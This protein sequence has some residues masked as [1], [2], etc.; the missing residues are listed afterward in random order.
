MLT[1]REGK[2]LVM[3]QLGEQESSPFYYMCE[4]Q[5]CDCWAIQG[6]EH[7]TATDSSDVLASKIWK[8]LCRQQCRAGSCGASC[9]VI[10]QTCWGLGGSEVWSQKSYN[11]VKEDLRKKWIISTV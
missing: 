2:R 6:K 4:L 5:S 11:L 9:R 10:E 8:Y 7:I 1:S 3:R